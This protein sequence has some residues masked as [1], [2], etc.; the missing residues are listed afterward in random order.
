MFTM[1]SL[2]PEYVQTMLMLLVMQ[3]YKIV[4]SIQFNQLAYAL[5]IHDGHQ[6]WSVTSPRDI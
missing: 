2:L 1:A 6:A 5:L 4:F 3:R